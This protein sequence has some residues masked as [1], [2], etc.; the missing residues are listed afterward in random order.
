MGDIG[1][2]GIG[3]SGG[4]SSGGGGSGNVPDPP[5]GP[6][7]VLTST[8]SGSGDYVWAKPGVI[9]AT[10]SDI[11]QITVPNTIGRATVN[12]GD[13]NV[14]FKLPAVSTIPYDGWRVW[15][16]VASSDGTYAMLVEPDGAASED[17][18][19]PATGVFQLGAWS[20]LPSSGPTASSKQGMGVLWEWSAGQNAWLS[21][22]NF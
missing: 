18:M 14:T 2:R 6:Q 4:T 11:V 1:R 8:G 16:W 3:S 5:P 15:T 22:A 21:F 20:T 12:A 19:N 17:I 7:Y 9:E 10:G 13:G